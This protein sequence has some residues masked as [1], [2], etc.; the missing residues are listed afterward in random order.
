MSLHLS[1]RPS[2][3]RVHARPRRRPAAAFP[4]TLAAA[5]LALAACSGSEPEA[6]PRTGAA[7]SPAVHG[8]A[9]AAPLTVVD[10]WVKTADKGMS[11]AFGTLVNTTGAEITVVSAAT[12]ASP[13][14]ELHEV[15]GAAGKMTMRPREGGF[16]I[17][18]RGRLDLRPGGFH[19]M[20]MDVVRPVR[21]GDP[22]AFTLTLKDG[23]TVRFTALGKAFKGGNE[24]YRP[25]H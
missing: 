13:S 8:S 3:R 20:L 7:T 1:L 23:G 18:A 24:T 4:V 6:A 15:T 17:P 19:I 25:G 5:V 11:A 9:A 21:P 16:V 22:V 10:P 14:V 12:P 2:P